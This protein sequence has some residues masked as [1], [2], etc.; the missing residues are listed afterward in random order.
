MSTQYTFQP[1]YAFPPGDTLLETLEALGLT[2]KELA[3]RMGRPLK[4]INQ[5]I[6][7][8]AQI[9]PETA[10]QLEKVT[11]VPASFWNNAE[12]N[13]RERLARLQ[14]EK[15][16]LE[17]VGWVDRFSYKKMADL[18]L[19]PLLTNKVERVGQLLRFFGVASPKQWESTY[20]GLCGAARES[21]HFKTDLGDLS[22]W[23]RTGEVLAQKRECRPYDK[24][25]F[26]ANLREIR[27]LTATNP[28]EAWPEVCRLC[29]EAGVAVVLV[30]EL[31]NTHVSGFTRWLTPEK[32]LIQLSLRY[33][34]DDSLW[35]TFFHEAAHILLHGKRD[36][37]IEFRGV[38]NPK[39][40]E[41]NTWA[42]D[43][44]IPPDVWKTFLA[45]LPAR[46]G[47]ATIRAFAKKQHIAPS[48]VL[49]RLQHREKRLS[50]G[51]FNSLKHKVEI[52]WEGLK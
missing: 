6:K 29:A 11:G 35:F 20:G 23:L 5:I 43:F 48:I 37:F 49:G 27:A 14:D 1:D 13:Y 4:T 24:E 52:A 8:T 15:R 12:S 47:I 40:Q 45:T 17:V 25:T 42:G 22:A 30:P 51:C 19:V 39:E 36:V 31:P 10:L 50:P 33:K 28:A 44:L 18:G 26:A 34:T 7:G 2:Q 38:D 3:T 41:A 46:P 32:A 9:M 16:Q 21:G